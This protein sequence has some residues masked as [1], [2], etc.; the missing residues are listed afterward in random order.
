MSGSSTKN[1]ASPS[2]P[3]ANQK[4]TVTFDA[5]TVTAAT[6]ATVTTTVTGVN[7]TDV[8]VGAN[9]TQ[10]TGL[11]CT[12][13]QIPAANV[14]ELKISNPTAGTITVGVVTYVFSVEHFSV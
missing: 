14:V 3:R 10:K 8:L 11:L 2:G 6:V 4:F 1:R 12:P 5:G 7:V 9:S 13:S